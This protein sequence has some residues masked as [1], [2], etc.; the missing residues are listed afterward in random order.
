MRFTYLDH[1]DVLRPNPDHYSHINVEAAT[2]RRNVVPYFPCPELYQLGTGHS[3]LFRFPPS[4]LLP[5]PFVLPRDFQSSSIR[6]PSHPR[7]MR[8]RWQ[9]L[10]LTAGFVRDWSTRPHAPNPGELLRGRFPSAASPAGA[11]IEVPSVSALVAGRLMEEA[12]AAVSPVLRSQCPVLC[13][14]IDLLAHRS[15]FGPWGSFIPRGV[16]FSAFKRIVTAADCFSILAH[17]YD[18][19]LISSGERACELPIKVSRTTSPSPPESVHTAVRPLNPR[20]K[21]PATN[22]LRAHCG[23]ETDCL[24]VAMMYI[25][26]M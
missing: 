3:P 1:G 8:A 15:S 16:S 23:Q 26:R 9:W 13:G 7:A 18:R 25:G 5:F 20:N 10:M 22:R 2:R 19:N 6:L 24:Y 21:E 11:G 17:R 4:L 12:A 14:F